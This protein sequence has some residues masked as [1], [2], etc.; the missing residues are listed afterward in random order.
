MVSVCGSWD[1]FES[2]N[3][4]FDLGRKTRF[5]GMK[6]GFTGKKMARLG[7]KVDDGIT[8]DRRMRSGWEQHQNDPA[9]PTGGKSSVRLG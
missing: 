7:V 3:N 4:A 2:V 8:P 9:A 5:R 1:G 6:V